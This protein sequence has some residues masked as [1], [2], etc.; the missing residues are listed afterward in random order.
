MTL[1][2]EEI[3]ELLDNFDEDY[4]AVASRRFTHRSVVPKCHQWLEKILAQLDDKRFKQMIRVSRAQFTLILGQIENHAVFHGKNSCHQFPVSTQLALVLF[5]LG[6]SGEG[7]SISKVS[8]L[9]GI[10]DGG[11]MEKITKRVFKVCLKYILNH[12]L[13]TCYVITKLYL[14]GRTVIIFKIHLLAEQGR[15]R[16]YR[17]KSN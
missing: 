8:A 5:R 11:S 4:A 14:L 1:D 17:F 3:D 16:I 7:A 13:N 10:G 6:S 12:R 15:K 9:L 2:E